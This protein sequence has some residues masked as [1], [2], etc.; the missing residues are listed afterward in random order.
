VVTIG[1][2]FESLRKSET[3]F[4]KNLACSLIGEFAQN[5]RNNKGDRHGNSIERRRT[6]KR[7]DG[8]SLPGYID[9]GAHGGSGIRRPTQ[10]GIDNGRHIEAQLY[11][12]RRGTLNLE[13]DLSVRSLL[14]VFEAGDRQANGLLQVG[15]GLLGVRLQV[16]P[17][18]VTGWPN[19]LHLPPGLFLLLS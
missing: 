17:G 5:S 11:K 3:P 16:L 18:I 7:S 13:R 19:L 8:K 9:G 2:I 4:F 1:N 14:L 15:H 12:E 10:Q 6:E